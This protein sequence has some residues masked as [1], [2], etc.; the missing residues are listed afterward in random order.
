MVEVPVFASHKRLHSVCRRIRKHN[1]LKLSGMDFCRKLCRQRNLSASSF[2][3]PIGLL[4]YRPYRFPIQ[5]V[6]DFSFCL[7]LF[8]LL[9]FY[10]CVWDMTEIICHQDEKDLYVPIISDKG[11]SDFLLLYF[12]TNFSV[13]VPAYLGDIKNEHN[14]LSHITYINSKKE[15]FLK[16]T[17]SYAY[18]RNFVVSLFLSAF[19]QQ[20]I[21]RIMILIIQSSYFSHKI[22][23]YLPPYY[24]NNILL[25]LRN[26]RKVKSASSYYSS[27]LS[28]ISSWK[29]W[30]LLK[31]LK[32][33]I[34]NL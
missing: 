20:I 27:T 2:F 4:S 9:T 5:F 21:N 28:F 34:T 25:T 29:N 10:L 18:K 7:V 16:F 11:G 19:N 6:W 26:H 1:L 33:N 32:F 23:L 15:K 13:H 30:I 31:I 8:G 3:T 22:R 12:Y 24:S 14:P 17:E